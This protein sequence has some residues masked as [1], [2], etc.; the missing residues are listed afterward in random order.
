M[1]PT[2]KAADLLKRDKLKIFP[3]DRCSGHR[4]TPFAALS[5]TLRRSSAQQ[6][7]DGDVPKLHSVQTTTQSSQSQLRVD[8]EALA[9]ALAVMTDEQFADHCRKEARDCEREAER[10]ISP[11][12]KEAW[13]R[14][15]REWAKLAGL[16]SRRG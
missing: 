13:L 10:T 7:S 14:L 8:N 4:S 9:R 1:L 15:S 6:E 12:D 3:Q 5:D 2:W 16:A 11:L